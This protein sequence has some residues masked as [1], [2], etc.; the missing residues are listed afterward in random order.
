MPLVLQLVKRG[1]QFALVV[2]QEQPTKSDSWRVVPCPVEIAQCIMV[3]TDKPSDPI[4][5]LPARG[6]VWQERLRKHAK[7][8]EGFGTRNGAGSYW[9]ALRAYCA[10]QKAKTYPLYKL[11][12]EMGWKSPDIAQ[13]YVNLAQAAGASG[14]WEEVE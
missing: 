12:Y 6:N 10:T 13:S 1:S 8:I 4:F 3:V 7:G 5:K 9:H 2:G 14:E 11:M